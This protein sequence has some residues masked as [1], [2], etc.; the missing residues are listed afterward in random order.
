MDEY[1]SHGVACQ[2]EEGG[3]AEGQNPG[4]PKQDIEPHGEDGKNHH[5]NGKAVISSYEGDDIRP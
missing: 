4:I 3:M 5:L 1:E 2:A